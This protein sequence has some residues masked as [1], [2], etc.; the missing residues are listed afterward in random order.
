[1]D[2]GRAYNFHGTYQVDEKNLFM[3][4]QN[5]WTM[6]TNTPH[7]FKGN[8]SAI[9]KINAG[10]QVNDITKFYLFLSNQGASGEISSRVCT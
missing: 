4:Y 10:N 9:I 6:I 1:M 7:V 5:F 8:Y 2:D 3:T